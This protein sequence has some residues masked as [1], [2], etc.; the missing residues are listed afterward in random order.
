[1]S[2]DDNKI[3]DKGARHLA[4]SL[5]VNL[6]LRELHLE[7]NRIGNEGTMRLADALEYNHV[8]EKL[9]L[10]RNPITNIVLTDNIDAMLADPNRKN[11]SHQHSPLDLLEKFISN[12]EEKMASLQ[13]D[14]NDPVR[15]I[16][17][18]LARKDAQIAALE[19]GRRNSLPIVETCDLTDQRRETKCRRARKH[20]VVERAA[21]REQL[22]R[23]KREKRDGGDAAAA[24]AAD[25]GPEEGGAAAGEICSR[26]Q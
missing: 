4:T 26:D 25:G 8:L 20:A 14:L 15:Q 11:P 6:S 5:L 13:A 17:R 7:G 10:E 16:D 21:L 24:T 9:A 22:L 3:G 1:M 19:A 18:M 23:V 12:K 2:L